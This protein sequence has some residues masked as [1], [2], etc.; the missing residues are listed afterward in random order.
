MELE[1][2]KKREEQ[3]NENK[4]KFLEIECLLVEAAELE[5]HNGE[6]NRARIES[7]RENAITK[8]FTM[9]KYFFVKLGSKYID[10][11]RFYNVFTDFIF[12]IPRLYKIRD[13]DGKKNSLENYVNRAWS[14]RKKDIYQGNATEKKH[15]DVTKSLEQMEE[16]SSSIEVQVFMESDFELKQFS[17]SCISEILLSIAKLFEHGYGK[18]NNRVREKYYKLFVTE[19]VTRVIKEMG[20]EEDDISYKNKIKDGIN[21]NFMD[22]F[23]SK[24][25]RNIKE[26]RDTNLTT[27]KQIGEPKKE[28]E[29]EY[30]FEACVYMNYL[31]KIEGKKSS[32]EIISQNK[33]Y[34]GEIL[35]CIKKS[36]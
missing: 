18:K 28:G 35:E 15:A 20:M 11:D 10:E 22:F 30:P 6:K 4:V 17:A 24:V 1:C 32:P 23:M 12:S 33:K 16:N 5:E 3:S 14:F 34:Y 27:Y 19:M 8:L 13:K 36:L 25:C 7:L 9:N 21:E 31:Q 29:I 26:I 2:D